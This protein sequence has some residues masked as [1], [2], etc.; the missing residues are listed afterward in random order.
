MLMTA[1]GNKVGEAGWMQARMERIAMENAIGASDPA[2]HGC[3]A[4]RLHVFAIL[5]R[6]G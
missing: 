6:A 2:S 3:N 5:A 4:G 1:P